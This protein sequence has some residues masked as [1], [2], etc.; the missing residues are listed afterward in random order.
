MEDNN[1]HRHET[2]ITK[3][4]W[5]HYQQIC[6]HPEVTR[7]PKNQTAFLIRSFIKKN[8]DKVKPTDEIP[9]ER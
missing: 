1:L 4:E 2:Q 9:E 5:E 3:T 6:K 7:E 8:L